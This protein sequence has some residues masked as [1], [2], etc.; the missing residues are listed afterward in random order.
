MLDRDFL[1]LSSSQLLD[2]EE[3]DVCEGLNIAH[4]FDYV[5]AFIC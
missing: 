5:C 3:S 2:E 4:S 1:P